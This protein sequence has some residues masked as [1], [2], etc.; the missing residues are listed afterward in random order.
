MNDMGKS[1]KKGMK[2]KFRLGECEMK[3]G[4]L[5]WPGGE[6]R[7]LGGKRERREK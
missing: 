5:K 2:L 6:K 3:N 4:G 7:G 1:K